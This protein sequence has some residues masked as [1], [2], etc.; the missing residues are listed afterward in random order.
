MN[1]ASERVF[2]APLPRTSPHGFM[3]LD[4]NGAD[5]GSSASRIRTHH[6]IRI[7]AYSTILTSRK[8]DI[9]N[10]ITIRHALR[11]KVEHRRSRQSTA[12][13]RMARLLEKQTPPGKPEDT[14]TQAR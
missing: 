9:R 3:G 11:P 5:S 10:E 7:P 1:S 12:C 14:L 13:G 2:E 6:P 8:T 4:Q